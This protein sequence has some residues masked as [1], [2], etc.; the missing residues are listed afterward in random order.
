MRTPAE[1]AQ[2]M[3]CPTCNAVPDDQCRNHEGHPM[4][5]PHNARY[6]A[7]RDVGKR[8]EENLASKYDEAVKAATK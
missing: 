7:W 6:K 4:R 2:Q 3:T 1:W 5:K 8:L